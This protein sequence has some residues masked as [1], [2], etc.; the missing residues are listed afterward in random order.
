MLEVKNLSKKKSHI[1]FLGVSEKVIS[2]IDPI[3]HSLKNDKWVAVDMLAIK[4]V[5][6]GIKAIEEYKVN[7]ISYSSS[8]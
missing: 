3:I 6:Q 8:I 2:E 5:Y 4:Q 7:G 1:I